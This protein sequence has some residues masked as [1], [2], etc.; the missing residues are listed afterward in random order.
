[1][2]DMCKEAGIQVQEYNEEYMVIYKL[3]LK[4][5][6]LLESMNHGKKKMVFMKENIMNMMCLMLIMMN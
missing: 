1:M 6:L 3:Q 4:K 5:R 2:Y